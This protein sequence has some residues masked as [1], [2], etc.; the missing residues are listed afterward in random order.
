MDFKDVIA[1]DIDDVFFEAT[2]FAENVIIDGRSVPIIMDNDA[3]NGKS[4]VYA[5]GLSEGEQLIFIKEK[6]MRRLP[7]PGEQ[8]SIN[9]KQ[10]YVRHALSSAG[11][12]EIRIGRNQLIG[13]G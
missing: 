9:G 6:D 4:D 1:A 2:E 12:F 3:L 7:L 5:L 8:M 10:W 13:S 11:I